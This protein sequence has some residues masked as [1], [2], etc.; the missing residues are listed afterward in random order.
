MM[1]EIT[2]D[3]KKRMIEDIKKLNDIQLYQILTMVKDC[4]SKYTENSNGVFVNLKNLNKETLSKIYKYIYECIDINSTVSNTI[5]DI[6]KNEAIPQM[7]S[8]SSDESIDEEEIEDED[9]DD[10]E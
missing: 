4:T 6:K 3:D 10:L 8:E 9:D 5:E 2:F 7:D 1:E